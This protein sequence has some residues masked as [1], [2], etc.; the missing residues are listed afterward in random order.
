LLISINLTIFAIALL[1][2][3]GKTIHSFLTAILIVF[4]LLARLF[5]ILAISDFLLT[6]FHTVCFSATAL[7]PCFLATLTL[8]H[9]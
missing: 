1:L 4:V 7:S 5:F 2:V 9:H 8:H 3:F 6:S